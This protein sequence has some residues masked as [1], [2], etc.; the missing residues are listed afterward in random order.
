MQRGFRPGRHESR[1]GP[2]PGPGPGPGPVEHALAPFRTL[3]PDR[4]DRT[5]VVLTRELTPEC[6]RLIDREFGGDRVSV[7][8]TVPP[9]DPGDAFRPVLLPELTVPAV[10]DALVRIGPVDVLLQHRPCPLPDPAAAVRRLVYH[11]R[12]HGVWVID[13]EPTGPDGADG[14]AAV[15]L[16][17][18]LVGT[19]A[20]AVG[21]LPATE[22]ELARAVG[23]VVLA[24][25]LVLVQ[26]ANTHH[27][28]LREAETDELLRRRRGVR[29][30]K[31]LAQ[32]PAGSLRSRATVRHY[33]VAATPRGFEPVLPYPPMVLRDYRGR[34]TL[35]SHSLILADHVVLP[36]S[37]RHHLARRLDH[38][39]TVDANDRFAHVP[40]RSRPRATLPGSYF[41]VDAA[42]SGHFGHVMTEVLSRLWAWPEAKQARPELQAIYHRS[43]RPERAL[44]ERQ[45]LEGFGI[46]PDDIVAVE[47]P[48]YL[49]GL[50]SAT[51]MWHN[52]HPRYVHPEI[53]E[54]WAQLRRNL[55]RPAHAPDRQIFVSRSE[56]L[57]AREC[58]NTFEVEQYFASRGFRVIYPEQHTLSEQATI[59]GAAEVV[60]GFAGSALL[61]IVFSADLKSLI[62]LGHH[63]YTARNEYL[64]ASLLGC[65]L[66]YLWCEPDVAHPPRRWTRE[67]FA[68]PWS[69]DFVRHGRDLDRITAR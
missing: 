38:P 67:G 30:P 10:E 1:S 58:R 55:I 28:K 41:H 56:T 40:A 68:S 5:V 39:R 43:N 69:F 11:L 6:R 7:L 29:G 31:I 9:V 64:M 59:F 61:N 52:Q 17:A 66:D 57:G 47:T 49:D 3:L 23:T 65:E 24:P 19:D 54:L 22:R 26:K 4:G 21:R 51:A 60:A 42:F 36:G 50:Q 34:I 25:G 8:S 48:V 15:E 35:A 62:V 33:G 32:R 13:R 45:L 53:T 12:R 44:V 27:L 63:G 20:A 18:G 14:S 2:D 16:L 46:A 37:Y